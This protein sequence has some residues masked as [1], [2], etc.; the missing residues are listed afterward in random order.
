VKLRAV[1]LAAKVAPAFTAA[2]GQPRLR[3]SEA[4]PSTYVVVGL[5]PSSGLA[6]FAVAL[7]MSIDAA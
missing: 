5:Q 2:F 7:A 4:A 1:R 6:H 3:P